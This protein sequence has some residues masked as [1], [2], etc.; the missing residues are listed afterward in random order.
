MSKSRLTD[1]HLITVQIVGTLPPPT[2]ATETD[3]Q[4]QVHAF[5]G[6][7]TR[8][9]QARFPLFMPGHPPCSIQVVALAEPASEVE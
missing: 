3:Y 9:F 8:A 7:V 5:L 4:Q 6:D 1:C 2:R